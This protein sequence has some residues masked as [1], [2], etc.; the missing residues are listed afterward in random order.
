MY[1]TVYMKNPGRV[2]FLILFVVGALGMAATG[3]AV[4]IRLMYLSALLLAVS[5]LWMYVSL[6]GV[7][8]QRHARSLRASM[9]DVFEE[10][11]EVKNIGRLP[12][13]YVEVLNE[14]ALP[15]AAGSRILGW[16]RPGQ[17]RSYSART[18]LTRRGAFSLGPTT[19][20]SG[21]PF[22]LFPVR[23]IIPGRDRLIV[24]P[25]IVPINEFF[26][27][28]GL[29]P[30]GKAIRRKS[31]E[32]TPHAS[33]VREYVTGDPLKR[34]HW[35]STARRDKLMVKEFEQDPQAEVWIFL[36][37][38]REVQAELENQAAPTWQD[39]IFDRRPELT[40]PPS[41]LEYGVSI[42]A[43]LAHYFIGRRRAVGLVTGG[44]VYTVIRAERSERQESKILETLA[45]VSGAG[46]L[47]LTS[48][49]DL[50][51]PQMPLGSSALLVTPAVD[52]NV[53]LAVDLL[54]RRNLRPVV[55]LL[56][57]ETFGGSPGS[58]ELAARLAQ[59]NIPVCRVHNGANLRETLSNFAVQSNPQESHS[60]R[61]PLSAH[62]I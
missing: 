21:D 47:S 32:V 35:A 58:E 49:V 62:S 61:E 22:G 34:I 15:Q 4:Y 5:F 13:L 43:S 16:V 20:A 27:P 60:W 12:R 55:I 45:F 41:T 28:L 57:A 6:A 54:Q 51:A 29:L 33:G 56:M 46:A 1:D 10:T 52:D 9:G 24:L 59:R 25:L 2:F 44:P 26:S 40:L 42:A 19:I 11:F 14:S 17:V 37:A 18:W 30:G 39:W 36:D 8:F 3:S 31:F 48:L 50:Q 7:Q 23:Q 38:Q 53:L